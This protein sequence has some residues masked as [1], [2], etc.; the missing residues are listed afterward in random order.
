MSGVKT[1]RILFDPRFISDAFPSKDVV[2]LEFALFVEHCR[3]QNCLQFQK[4]TQVDHC[5]KNVLMILYWWRINSRHCC[6][7]FDIGHLI[8]T[9][10]FVSL[11]M[12]HVQLT[13]LS[14]NEEI[15]RLHGQSPPYVSDYADA[16]P[17]ILHKIQ[18]RDRLGSVAARPKLIK[19]ISCRF[20]CPCLMARLDAS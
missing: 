20:L 18:I 19:G 5:H 1:L 2:I 3:P 7:V 15:N 9:T 6:N 12:V 4:S 10:H 16:V 8:Q 17:N 11:L 13:S 14:S